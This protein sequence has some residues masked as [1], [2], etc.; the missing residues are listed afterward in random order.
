M[1]VESNR[2]NRGNGGSVNDRGGYRRV[3]LFIPAYPGSH[4]RYIPLQAGLG[5]ISQILDQNGIEN[6][7]CDMRLGYGSGDLKEKVL[8]YRPDL[9]GIS[10]MT[11]KY[12]DTYA[13]ISDVKE[14]F[15]SIPIVAGGPH[16]STLREN[17]LSECRS[18]DY[19]V[20]LEGE[21][22]IM[23][24]C[25]GEEL[26]RIKGLIYRS[27][28]GDVVSND[29]RG[30]IKDL[31]GIPFP[32]YCKFEMH[33]CERLIPIVSSRG[34]PYQCIYCPVQSA[35]GKKYRMRSSG[36]VVDEMEFWYERGFRRQG[37]ADDNF[38][39]SRARIYE[40]CDE[41]EK[42]GLTGLRLGCSNG[43]RADR[44]DRKLLSR[45]RE[46]GFYELAFGVEAGTDRVLERL[47][48]SEKIEVIRQAIKDSCELGYEVTLFFLL[49]SP[50]ET[51]SDVK[52]SIDLVLSYPVVSAPFYNLIPFPNTELFKWVEKKGYLLK[53]PEEYL[54]DASHWKNEPVFETPEL[55]YEK[56]KE[57]W[58]WANRV[59][60]RHCRKNRRRAVKTKLQNSLGI[61]GLPGDLFSH[62]W[63]S[64]L[65]Q[66]KVLA[67]R[68][69]RKIRDRVL[70]RG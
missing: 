11:F 44:V 25:L 22:T 5:Y 55:P 53:S 15:P 49:G 9:I 62:V 24:L 12:L 68:A 56:R 2:E 4:Y 6:S 37:F 3:L 8:G 41:I 42:R 61:K 33:K 65:V 70:Q 67:N 36:N 43:V 21:E 1:T 16:V 19:G 47:H 30:F 45:M 26:N 66:K 63:C 18:I 40:I 34:C 38:T 50:G 23:E 57:A 60:D 14:A 32:D 20:V 10:M 17:V 39:I 31:D 7:V 58:A 35:I 69:M 64:D 28:I 54:N 52:E 48:K 51:W 59:A 13:V 46:V 29:D 27:D